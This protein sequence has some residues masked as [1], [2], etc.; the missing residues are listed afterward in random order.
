[1]L[2]EIERRVAYINNPESENIKQDEYKNLIED[3]AEQ[4]Q[5][6][7]AHPEE[8]EVRQQQVP[9][10]LAPYIDKLAKGR[11]IARGPSA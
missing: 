3:K 5:F 1:M 10:R 9:D 7:T 2:D 4:T 6:G 8:F 11:S